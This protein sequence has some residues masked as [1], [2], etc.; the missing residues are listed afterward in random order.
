ML[1]EKVN[2]LHTHFTFPTS[3]QKKKKIDQQFLI[4]SRITWYVLHEKCDQS[5]IVL[6]EGFCIPVFQKPEHTVATK[7]K[8][9]GYYTE[10][11]LTKYQPNKQLLL[12]RKHNFFQLFKH[13]LQHKR[14]TR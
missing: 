1:L 14:V 2:R 10:Q 5:I 11:L 13:L 4:C 8:H 6:K 3:S 7:H 12:R 9:I